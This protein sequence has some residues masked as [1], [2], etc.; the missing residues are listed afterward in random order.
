MGLLLL[1]PPLW[2]PP[3][4][5]NT[6]KHTHTWRCALAPA[7]RSRHGLRLV[8]GLHTRREKAVM[9]VRMVLLVLLPQLQLLLAVLLAALSLLPHPVG[10]SVGLMRRPRRRHP[11]PPPL[12]PPCGDSF[13]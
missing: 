7:L 12:L 4:P 2:P 13:G 10:K 1:S 11:P 3:P 5:P 8:W 6:H 9:H